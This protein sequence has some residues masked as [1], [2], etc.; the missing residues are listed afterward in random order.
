[1]T[2]PVDLLLAAEGGS[3]HG[4]G[5]VM[6]CAALASD[7]RARGLRVG[8]ALRGDEG[9]RAALAAESLTSLVRPWSSPLVTRGAAGAVIFDARGEIAPAVREAVSAGART[10]VLDRLDLRDV[11]DWTVLP[12]AHAAPCPHP[13]VRQGAAWCVI[14]PEVRG[15]RRAPLE[16]R[17]QRALVTLGGADPR[18][19][20]ERLAPLV[21]SRLGEAGAAST[22]VVVGAAFADGPALARWLGRRG[23]VVHVAPS[24]RSLAAL[25]ARSTFAV[26]GFGTTVYELAFLGVPCVYVAH[27]S[28]DVA[29]ARRLEAVGI[30][31]FGGVAEALDEAVLGEALAAGPLDP[32]WRRARA[33]QGRALLDDGA[34]GSRILDLVLT[35]GAAQQRAAS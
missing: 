14:A 7:A 9:A 4:L 26:C 2:G 17:Q 19:L 10:L 30:G 8:I 15:L 28:A 16:R 11:A 22:D 20:T 18:R 33:A 21:A 27:R 3:E 5:H 13:R 23:F 12:V 24:R 25:A 1:M 6:R 34:G 29:D 35:G 32:D 31:G